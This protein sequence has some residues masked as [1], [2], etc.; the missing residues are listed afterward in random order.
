MPGPDENTQP[1]RAYDEAVRL[2]AQALEHA[3]RHRSP[4]LPRAYEVWFTYV[5]GEDRA[6][7]ER[8]DRE[9]VE[10]PVVDLGKIEQIYQEHFLEKRLAGGMTAISD[11]LDAGL[12]DA[13]GVMRDGLGT[14]QR[15]L[16][17]LRQAQDRI[18]RLSRKQDARR[19]VVELLAL[20]RAH[21]AQTE[22]LNGELAKVRGQVL[23]LQAEL[24]RLRDTAYLDHLTQISNRRHMEEVLEREIA[25]ARAAGQSL[26]FALA[27]LDHFKGLNDSFGHAVGDAVLKHFAGLLKRNVKGQDTPAR[28]GGEEFAV[29]LPRTAL[30]HAAHLADGIRRQLGETSFVLSRERTPIG[31]ITASFGVTQL[32]PGDSMATLIRRADALLYRAK[33]LGRNRVESD[34]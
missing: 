21:S 28:F 2:A 27:D 10:T 7:R 33:Q 23:E 34:L 22:S 30:F 13:I 19:A 1:D 15:F 14:S 25:Q 26:S 6:L 16:G 9:L 20:A 24:K 5:A 8:I 4:P 31:P 11:E 32:L 29:I 17:S 18:S 12:R 3:H